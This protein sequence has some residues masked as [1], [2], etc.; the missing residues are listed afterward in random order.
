MND[1]EKARAAREA[2]EAAQEHTGTGRTTAELA[3]VTI[4]RYLPA[5]QRRHSAHHA[6]GDEDT[7]DAAS[8]D[9]QQGIEPDT[10]T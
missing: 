5:Q 9:Q 8:E 3:E 10:A 7:G 1:I 6:E 2:R 4:K